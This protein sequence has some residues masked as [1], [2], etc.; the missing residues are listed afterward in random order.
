[1]DN[2]QIGIK[3]VSAAII[4]FIIVKIR[5]FLDELPKCGCSSPALK[6]IRLLE[7]VIIILLIVNLFVMPKNSGNIR[8]MGS[9]M[10][11]KIMLPIAVLLYLYLTYNTVQFSNDTNKD[12]TCK[13]CTNKWEKYALYAQTF[14]YGLSAAMLIIAS[15]ML[16]TLGVVDITSSYGFM[17]AVGILFLLG[18]ATTTIYGGSINDLLDIVEKNTVNEGFCGCAREEEKK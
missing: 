5:Q 4:V 10:Y 1:M 13:K 11:A 17:L 7:L 18:I 14:I 9:S 3:A 6:R 2:T 12:E 16:I 8:T 15:A